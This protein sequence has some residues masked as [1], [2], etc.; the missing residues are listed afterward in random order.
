MKKIEKEVWGLFDCP[1]I[2]HTPENWILKKLRKKM[3]KILLSSYSRKLSIRK[4]NGELRNTDRYAASNDI[5][6]YT[7]FF[8]LSSCN[9]YL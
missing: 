1:N 6:I 2:K 8:S 9:H 4:G 3:K 5:Y 7:Q